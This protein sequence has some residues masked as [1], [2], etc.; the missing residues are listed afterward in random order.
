MKYLLATAI[1][2]LSATSFAAKSIYKVDIEIESNQTPK[3]TM[4]VMVEEDSEGTVTTQS[5]DTTTSFKVRPTKTSV[6]GKDA[7]ALAMNFNHF[8]DE[9]QSR[10]EHSPHVIV[11]EGQAASIEVGDQWTGL[12]YKM[13]IKATKVQ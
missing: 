11:P 12:E 4:S 2:F 13:K 1:L 7:I 10:V 3:T 6:E 8:S 5:E 9:S